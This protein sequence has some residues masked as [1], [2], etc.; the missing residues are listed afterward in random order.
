MFRNRKGFF[1]K[2]F[3]AL[4]MVITTVVFHGHEP[5]DTDTTP[6]LEGAVSRSEIIRQYLTLL[7]T[8]TDITYLCL[9]L[10]RLKSDITL[11]SMD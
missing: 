5:L 3:L 9:S 11:R 4:L 10:L 1:S 7:D 6:N 2:K 8:N